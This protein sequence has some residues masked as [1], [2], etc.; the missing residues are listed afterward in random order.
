MQ[1]GVCEQGVTGARNDFNFD[2][3]CYCLQESKEYHYLDMS[4]TVKRPR[5]SLCHTP[6]LK[7]EGGRVKK[8]SCQGSRS[9]LATR[10][11]RAQN[12]YKALV[13]VTGDNAYARTSK[14]AER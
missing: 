9:K 14:V 1:K 8:E 10:D 4:A 6:P 5:A 7:G 11:L 3:Y 12:W 13:A 2:M